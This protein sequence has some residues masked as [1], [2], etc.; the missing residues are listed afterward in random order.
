LGERGREEQKGLGFRRMYPA[1]IDKHLGR[2]LM[3]RNR[4]RFE[5][6]LGPTFA[7]FALLALASPAP[8]GQAG[9][10]QPVGKLL[11]ELDAETSQFRLDDGDPATADP[12][13]LIFDQK[14]VKAKDGCLVG[15]TPD[16]SDPTH[17]NALVSLSESPTDWG[18]DPCCSPTAVC[19]SRPSR[20]LR[21]S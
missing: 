3:L 5:R 21:R 11:L 20:T 10:L 16:G 8:A 18:I 13:Q 7:A 15:L 17:P 2:N 19:R 14:I 6:G 9:N 12:V 4:Q 1:T